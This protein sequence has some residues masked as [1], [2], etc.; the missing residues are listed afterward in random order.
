MNRRASGR[1]A[2]VEDLEVARPGVLV[3]SGV[4]VAMQPNGTPSPEGIHK[5][6]DRRRRAFGFVWQLLLAAIG[7]RSASCLF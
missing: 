2:V 6:C 1:T 5:Q 7:I 4:C 3:G